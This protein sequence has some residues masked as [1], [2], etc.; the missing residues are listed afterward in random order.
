MDVVG[1]AGRTLLAGLI[2]DAG[3]FPPARLPMAAALDAH[4]AAR[5]SDEGW[6]LGRFLCPSSRVDELLV[7][8]PRGETLRL[9]VVVDSAELPPLGDARVA[10]ETVEVRVADAAAAAAYP[11]VPARASLAMP[12]LRITGSA[13][14]P[15]EPTGRAERVETYAPKLYFEGPV[16][17]A[18][19]AARRGAGLKIR[20]GGETAQ[21]FPS[22]EAVGLFVAGCRAAGV[23]FKATAGLHHAVRQ[24]D[25]DTGFTHHGFLN[26]LAA[27]ALAHEPGVSPG[28]LTEVVGDEDR[29]SFGLGA[30]GLRWRERRFDATACE[31]ARGFFV[32]FGSCSF[33]EPIDELRSLGVLLHA[34]A[35]A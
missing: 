35:T 2:D 27:A 33:S 12:A 7:E 9:G 15:S 3:L 18:E 26:L 19:A 23:P 17:A 1:D 24:I 28:E 34:A 16:A 4:L 5:M 6:I 31:R 11:D 22:P 21:A 8:L 13:G 30:D 32:G 10:L 25:P 20:C 14:D 29:D